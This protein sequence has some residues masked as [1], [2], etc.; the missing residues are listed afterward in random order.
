ANNA[1]SM[2]IFRLAGSP[3]GPFLPKKEEPILT[4]IRQLV[5]PLL[6]VSFLPVVGLYND[7][8]WRSGGGLCGDATRQGIAGRRCRKVA[9]GLGR[10]FPPGALLVPL[11]HLAMPPKIRSLKTPS[12]ASFLRRAAL[13]AGQRQTT[14]DVALVVFDH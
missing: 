5:P 14:D 1:E 12:G 13:G 3:R 2:A 11:G 7:S 4:A 6:L 9:S 8:A 10:A